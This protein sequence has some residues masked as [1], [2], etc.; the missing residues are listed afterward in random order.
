MQQQTG[1]TRHVPMSTN[2]DSVSTTVALMRRV[3]TRR[4]RSIACAKKVSPEM[5]SHFAIGR[6]YIFFIYFKLLCCNGNCRFSFEK[7]RFDMKIKR[8]FDRE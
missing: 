5:E 3:T 2:V 7:C 8:T 6:K 4:N 1:P